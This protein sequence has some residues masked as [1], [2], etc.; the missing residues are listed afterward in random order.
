MSC[1]TM[2]EYAAEIIVST[3]GSGPIRDAW[4]ILNPE[5]QKASME[6]LTIVTSPEEIAKAR[7]QAIEKRYQANGID[8]D[9]SMNTRYHIARIEGEEWITITQNGNKT[10][11]P[12]DELEYAVST[13]R[14]RLDAHEGDT[15]D[16]Q[17]E[18]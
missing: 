4:A 18:A 15:P 11:H 17:H 12:L 13:A 16:P 5:Q 8:W 2:A 9:S 7:M 10:Q 1:K 14:Q 6:A 3:Q